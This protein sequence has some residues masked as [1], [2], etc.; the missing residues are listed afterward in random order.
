MLING[1]SGD[2]DLRGTGGNDTII[3]S[4]GDDRIAGATRNDSLNG[5][6]GDDTILGG[7]GDDTITFGAGEKFVNGNQGTDVIDLDFTNVTD[8]DFSLIYNSTD[9]GITT[10]GV[11]SGTRIEGIEEVNVTSGDGNDRINISGASED[12]EIITGRGDDLVLGGQGDDLII[13]GGGDDTV[14][15]DNGNDTIIGGFGDDILNGQSGD[16]VITFGVGANIVDGGGGDDLLELDFSALTAN[17]Q[18]LYNQFEGPTLTEQSVLQGTE[19]DEIEQADITTGIG[20]DFIDI[21]ATTIGSVLSS[22]GG[23]DTLIGGS[24]DDELLG[25]AD[26]D[27]FFAGAG[28]DTI[29]GGTGDEDIAV[30]AGDASDYEIAFGD[31]IITLDNGTEVDELTNIDFLRFEDGDI[32]VETEVFTSLEDINE[33]L[34]APRDG[35]FNDPAPEDEES[36]DEESDTEEP[37]AEESED[38]ESETEELEDEDAELETAF[39]ADSDD[40]DVDAEID[41]DL[42]YQLT[43]TDNQTQFYTTSES[44]RNLVLA[45]QPEYELG[46]DSFIGADAPAEGDDF[47]GISPVYSFFNTST[48]SYLYTSQEAEK[49]FITE[50]L[51]NYV[52]EGVA[53]YSFDTQEEGTVPL[54]RVYNTNLG[55]HS[56]T[57]SAAQRDSF[58]ASGDFVI[59]GGED[60]AV[61]Y[62]EPVAEL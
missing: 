49:S 7:F 43:R 41:G 50:N 2:D 60:G 47:A 34:G 1:T 26:N 45:T 9:G 62:V 14:S 15:G 8:D 23:L 21:A 30:F 61:F 59:E 12:S 19:I 32:N 16:D 36:E 27:T 31:N 33:M 17:I 25:G 22:N 20:N 39:V 10:E 54:Y 44:E 55:T 6:F 48:E 18:L 37:E 58:L 40:S 38:E 56:F 5:G 42:V 35:V 13:T 24:G 57:T 28:S 4:G 46:T 53:Y 29:D 52:L 3:G 51:D 11:L